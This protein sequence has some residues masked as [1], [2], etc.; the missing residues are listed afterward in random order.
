[1][2]MLRAVGHWL[3]VVAAAIAFLALMWL[4]AQAVFHVRILNVQTGSMQPTFRPGDALIMQQIPQS[5]I[6]RGMIVAYHSSHYDNQLVTHRVVQTNATSLRTKGDALSTIDPMVA[7]SQ[8]SGRVVT[9]LPGLGKLLGFIQ[10]VP[11]LI[12]CVYLPAG[13]VVMGELRRLYT[14]YSGGGTYRLATMV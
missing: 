5:Q 6:D 3:S 9:V 1:M 11:G 7:K 12:V 4:L 2:Y 14:H 8:V 10:T 13:A